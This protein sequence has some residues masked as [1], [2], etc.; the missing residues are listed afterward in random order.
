MSFND[1]WHPAPS[2]CTRTP[3]DPK[4]Q[5]DLSP[6][7]LGEYTITRALVPGT[8]GTRHTIRLGKVALG[9]QISPPDLDQCKSHHQ[10]YDAA[11]RL[12]KDKTAH[13]DIY[14]P[15]PERVLEF[16]APGFRGTST[17]CMQFS[18]T[19][20]SLMTVLD[21]LTAEEKLERR[22]R[23]GRPEY[24][25]PLTRKTASSRASIE[26]ILS[27]ARQPLS[28]ADIAEKLGCR[29]QDISAQLFQLTE[30]GKIDR[31]GKAR[32]FTYQIAIE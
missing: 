11:A 12:S 19:M 26:S 8:P 1:T 32:S 22:L 16:C 24:R 15:T 29:P 18:C 10:R 27:R 20:A 28:A 7:Q 5:R 30:A 17:I 14:A 4:A 9:S 2:I 13:V 23:R 21:A 31:M 6:Y 25:V 3:Y